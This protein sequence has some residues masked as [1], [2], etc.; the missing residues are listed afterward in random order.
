MQTLPQ[1]GLQPG[2]MILPTGELVNQVDW[3]DDHFYDT[4]S[5]SAAAI[6]LG[7]EENFFSDLSGK[8]LRQT[9]LVEA[10]RL[11][12]GWVFII[13]HRPMIQVKPVGAFTGLT[14][15]DLHADFHEI[16][17]SVYFEL[18]IGNT[19]LVTQGVLEDYIYPYGRHV[20][21]AGT[22]WTAADDKIWST[23]NNGIPHGRP[24]KLDIPIMVANQNNF[25][26]KVKWFRGPTLNEAWDLRCVLKGM[27]K[28]PVG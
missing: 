25:R 15:D 21:V 26:G 27:V 23:F 9:N 2:Q 16:M 20:T 5:K 10:N 4:I 11:P 3:K 13:T 12:V 19:T 8:D 28:R 22:S 7:T 1:A 24:E 17:D 6:A 18:M 14:V